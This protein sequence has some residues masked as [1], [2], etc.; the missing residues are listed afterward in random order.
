LPAGLKRPDRTVLRGHVER[1]KATW[2]TPDRRLR[3]LLP[4]AVC[5]RWHQRPLRRNPRRC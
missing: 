1:R 3:A 5:V 2:P 4:V